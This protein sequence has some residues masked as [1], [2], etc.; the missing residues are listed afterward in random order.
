MA[1]PRRG[2]VPSTSAA[3]LLLATYNTQPAPL[4]TS[5]YPRTGKTASPVTSTAAVE[6]EGA[7]RF[8]RRGPPAA[9]PPAHLLAGKQGS[10]RSSCHLEDQRGHG[11]RMQR[12]QPPPSSLPF[13]RPPGSSTHSI[14]HAS[15]AS[16]P[17]SRE[18]LTTP[19]YPAPCSSPCPTPIMTATTTRRTMQV[20]GR[21][22]QQQM[23]L[24]YLA[25]T[26]THQS[27]Q[28]RAPACSPSISQAAPA[29]PPP[30]ASLSLSSA[31]TSSVPS[32]SPSR[33]DLLQSIRSFS[34][35]TLA[36]TAHRRT[37]SGEQDAKQQQ[38]D[39][40]RVHCISTTHQRRA[41]ASSHSAPL[42]PPSV[43]FTSSP[44]SSSPSRGQ[45]LQSIR[46]FAKSNL[47]SGPVVKQLNRSPVNSNSSDS[48]RNRNYQHRASPRNGLGVVI[49]R[50]TY[51]HAPISSRAAPPPP[52]P[53]PPSF[54]SASASNS[55]SPPP[56]S[57]RQNLL[58]CI[59]TFSKVRLKKPASVPA[60]RPWGR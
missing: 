56:S 43:P 23:A 39:R 5:A 19:P 26:N 10:G 58:Q 7:Q 57:S 37:A 22:S 40:S 36:A 50:P 21:S 47:T 48:R 8:S 53:P 49:S 9:P 28:S 15:E 13:A 29:P 51:T 4:S 34:K 18:L 20:K 2:S 31:P 35:S 17:P 38:A 16:Q 27:H 6:S 25:T 33:Q 46:A 44:P 42:S 11:R 24:A 60:P 14:S 55:K 32:P 3:P 12:S 54:A 59:R 45:L 52:P 30:F 41:P 1:P